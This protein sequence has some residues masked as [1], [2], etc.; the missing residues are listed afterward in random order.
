MFLY[1]DDSGKLFL[2]STSPN[3]G[4]L[5]DDKEYNTSIKHD[6]FISGHDYQLKDGEIID[7]GKIKQT[8]PE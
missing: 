1:F 8:K 7:L 3:A 2:N 4:F 5:K 6:D